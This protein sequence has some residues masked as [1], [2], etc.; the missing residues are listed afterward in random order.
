MINEINLTCKE[1]CEAVEGELI[2]E[3]AFISSLTTSSQESTKKPYCFFA[4]KGEKHNGADYIEEA[5]SNGAKLIV[6]QEKKPHSVSTIYVKDTVKALGLLG[7]KHKGK[8]KIIGVTGSNGKTT[9]KDMILTVLKEKYRVCAT[10]QNNNN[11]IGVAKTLLSINKHDYCVVEMG[12]RGLGEIE[13]LSYIC[14]PDIAVITNCSNAH[15]GRL[16][17]E[18]N[19]FKAK[20]EILKYT[21]A[22]AVLPSE[23]RFKSLEAGGL[24]HIFV[25]KNGDYNS[26][27]IIKANGVINFDIN[28]KS[29]E[30]N[31]ISSHDVQNA[32]LSY[33]VGRLCGIEEYLIKNGLKKWKKARGRGE[34]MEVNGIKIINDTYNA[35]FESMRSAVEALAEYGKM[36]YKTAAV[37]GDMLEQGDKAEEYHFKI[38]ELCKKMCIDKLLVSGEYS[39]QY[40]CG[41]GKGKKYKTIAEIADGIKEELSPSYVV[42]IKASHAENYGEIISKLRES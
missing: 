21:K 14:E 27:R 25:G 24:E 5:I 41:F 11:E 38:G 32:M 6:T 1:I 28:G 26:D 31:S 23:E 10:N 16:G 8:T 19:I 40:I 33:A 17:S 12:M 35:S 39:N 9:V 20:T 42:L 29:F 2:G 13:W 37:I 18:E 30:I 36:G 4:I 34:I 22:Y 3:D 15:I 7:K